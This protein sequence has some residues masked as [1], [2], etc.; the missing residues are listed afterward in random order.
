MATTTEIV[1]GNLPRSLR[2]ED[3]RSAVPAMVAGG[4]TAV[5]VA[6]LTYRAGFHPVAVF[7]V[8]TLAGLS[9]LLVG[10]YATDQVNKLMD[11]RA[12]VASPTQ[13]TLQGPPTAATTDAAPA[14]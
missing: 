13:T 6:V 14:T 9:V 12:S 3:W 11:Y 2:S 10:G 5:G 4:A 1:I 7:G 8:S